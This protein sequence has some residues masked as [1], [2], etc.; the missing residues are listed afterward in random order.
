MMLLGLKGSGLTTRNP[1]LTLAHL[2]PFFN[3]PTNSVQLAYL[4]SQQRQ[5]IGGIGLLAESDNVYFDPS[6]QQADVG[7]VKDAAGTG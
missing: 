7:K 5:A 2:D 3:D 4:F 6:A 1:Q